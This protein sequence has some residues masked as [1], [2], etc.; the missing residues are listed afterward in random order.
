MVSEYDLKQYVH[1]PTRGNNYLDLVFSNFPLSILKSPH[2]LDSDHNSFEF[3]INFSTTPNE[4]KWDFEN[5]NLNFKKCNYL[6]LKSVIE[7]IDWPVAL[8]LSNNNPNKSTEQ[9]YSILHKALKEAAPSI[10]LTKHKR[11]SWWDSE[12][13]NHLL[14]KKE[15][16]TIYKNSKSLVDYNNF[17]FERKRFKQLFL[18]K[19]QAYL[20]SIEEMITVN[21]D[22]KPFWS[23]LKK[24][25]TSSLHFPTMHY[26]S[27]SSDKPSE[28]AEYFKTFFIS[29]FSN[30]HNSELP[31]LDEYPN[32][33]IPLPHITS[34]DVINILSLVSSKKSL[35]PNGIPAFI[36]SNLKDIL[37]SPLASLFN[38][39]LQTG[40][41]PDILKRTYITPIFKKGDSN[42]V[43]SYRPIALL[44]H[45]SKIFEK[46]LH[47]H[48]YNYVSSVI[49][50]N[51]H[52]FVKKRSTLTNLLHLN[53]FLIHN[54]DLLAQIDVIYTDFCKAFD[55]IIFELL[56]H[57]LS[58]FN[59]HPT[60]LKWFRSYLTNR[61]NFVLYNGHK[62]SKYIP[63]SGV[64]QGSVLGPLLFILFINDLVLILKNFCLLYADDLKIFKLI[65][66]SLDSIN[67]NLSLAT[68]FKWCST[69]DL[70]LNISKCYFISFYKTKQKC[71]SF[72]YSINDI[73]LQ[74]VTT[75]KDLGVM[76]TSNFSFQPHINTILKKSFKMLGFLKRNSVYFT[77]LKTIL[78]LF[79]LLVL[80]HL[81][82]CS[83]IWSP[84]TLT[85]IN[86]IE[87][88]QR[89][90]VKFLCFKFS[91]PYVHTNYSFYLSNLSIKTLYTR[92]HLNNLKLSHEAA[93]GNS[94]L[95]QLNSIVQPHVPPRNTRFHLLYCL[96][97][98]KTNIY[99]LHPIYSTL[100][101]CNNNNTSLTD[102]LPNLLNSFSEILD[103]IYF[104]SI[105][106]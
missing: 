24:N 68:L 69:W 80:P 43:T 45:I 55:R 81:E 3:E 102:T 87:R 44:C 103:N 75:I 66:S 6:Q 92:R 98:F 106:V 79:K 57:K 105:Y 18:T 64:P 22:S 2:I 96:P 31:H 59:F 72:N 16:H 41:F 84:Y 97:R 101:L 61:P 90:F 99:K 95:P 63:T 100:E 12:L 65:T 8:D 104:S 62:S 38:L 5:C 17:S 54:L 13:S 42:D 1:F 78:T 7:K 23:F 46:L 58:K 51:Q 26:G 77:N 73:N 60:L 14:K 15:S 39:S 50:P 83:P 34:E 56:I 52:G 21:S 36:F 33:S 4:F 27:L 71:F 85:N 32:D 76:Y 93:L 53:N 29:T 82:Y 49:S 9:F 10:K 86:A 48:I 30:K 28:I 19:K 88:V 74:E 37:A 47:R 35:S 25:K 91:I 67:L 11:V 89:K 94:Q 40:I 20:S 70:E